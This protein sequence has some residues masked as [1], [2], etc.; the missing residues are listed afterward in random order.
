MQCARCQHENRPQATFCE[1]C[2][3]PLTAILSGPP[4]PS[5]GQVTSAL[6]EALEQ[7]A[8]TADILRVISSSPMDVQ[9]AFDTIVKNVVRLCD[10]VHSTVFRVDEGRIDL[11]A[12]HNV[13]P[14]GLEEL[15]RRYPALLQRQYRISAGGEGARGRPD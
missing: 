5:Y 8:A 9:P 4:A 2:G 15:R 14:E 7:Q 13:P 6:N 10:A 12:H 1:A 11:V 3:T